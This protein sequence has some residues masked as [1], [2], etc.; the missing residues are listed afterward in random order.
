LN[1]NPFVFILFYI[2]RKE[3]L[4]FSIPK[5]LNKIKE[6]SFNFAQLLNYNIHEEI[7]N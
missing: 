4:I 2:L 7:F 5:Y 1:Q 3:F 6:K